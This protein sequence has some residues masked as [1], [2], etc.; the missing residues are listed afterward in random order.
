MYEVELIG[1]LRML[2]EMGYMDV[3]GIMRLTEMEVQA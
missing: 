3:L 1:E 2:D